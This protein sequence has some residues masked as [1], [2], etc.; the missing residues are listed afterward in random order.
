MKTLNL[1]KEIATALRNSVA[2]DL[3]AR[4]WLINFEQG[5]SDYPLERFGLD[6]LAM[7]E[8]CIALEFSIGAQLSPAQLAEET[9]LLSVLERVRRMG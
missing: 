8:F 3:E 9:T 5:I 4:T 6:S 1:H 7:M 2:L